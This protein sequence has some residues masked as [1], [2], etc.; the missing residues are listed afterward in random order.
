MRSATA[1][2]SCITCSTSRMVMP[3]VAR[4][5]DQQRVE[6]ARSRGCA[7][8]RPARRAAAASAWRER[9]RKVEHLLVAEIELFGRVLR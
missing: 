8:Q 7:G 5:I 4:E 1:I 9:A 2:T 3:C 6:R